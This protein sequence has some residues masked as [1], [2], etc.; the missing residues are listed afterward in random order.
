M[1]L[2]GIRNMA[3]V[4]NPPQSL[5]NKCVIRA[6]DHE[7]KV[8][9]TLVL[10]KNLGEGV[11]E[12]PRALFEGEHTLLA[13]N[14]TEINFNLKVN[15]YPHQQEILNKF[16]NFYKPYKTFGGIIKAKTGTGKTVI[17]LAIAQY[18]G[19][20]T[21]IVVPTVVLL[22]QWIN[23]ILEH[24]TLTRK[25]IGIIQGSK[26][27]ID[28]PI[29]IGILKSLAEI[30]YH[31]SVYEN[32]GLTIYDEGHLLGAKTF[33]QVAPK[34]YDKFRLMLSATPRRK[35]NADNV[36]Y[37]HIGRIIVNDTKVNTVPILTIVKYTDLNHKPYK[38]MAYGKFIQSRF[39]NYIANDTK[40]NKIIADI[41]K[42]AYN[43][44]RH[45]LVLSDRISQLENIAK[46]IDGIDYGF[47]IG[48][49]QDKNHRVILGTYQVA[50]LG[51]DVKDLDVLI[52]ATPRTDIEQAVGRITRKENYE[53]P[54]VIVDIVD[55]KA[56]P[57]Q[58][59]FYKRN[60][61][62]KDLGCERRIINV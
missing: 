14:W 24:T 3:V 4:E 23:R 37:Y 59:Y 57:M 18:I 17:G 21:L 56:E 31:K 29:T 6:L 45:I 46:M 42:K 47:V 26:C 41:I 62:Y 35:D 22:N 61:F 39:L 52:F 7:N 54:P 19:L 32:F 53:K 40:R 48:G 25:D 27:V 36:F 10:F 38:Y 8:K 49:K 55:M 58:A 60:R 43:K 1:N 30:S 5:L 20:R 13:S 12:L 44:G 51:L 15:L 16:K 33:S 9:H 11:Y 50:G 34:F 2:L 28:K